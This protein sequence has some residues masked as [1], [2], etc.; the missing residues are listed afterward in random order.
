VEDYRQLPAGTKS[1]ES[2]E[3]NA[4]NTSS[5]QRVS[6]VALAMV[7]AGSSALAACSAPGGGPTAAPTPV[8]AAVPKPVSVE[9]SVVPLSQA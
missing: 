5:K 3:G 8:V 4:M 7:V 2:T 6:A 1:T 9:G